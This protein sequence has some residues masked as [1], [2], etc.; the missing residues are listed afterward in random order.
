MLFR[1]K[2]QSMRMDVESY[3]K[4]F[5]FVDL[6]AEFCGGVVGTGNEPTAEWCDINV[7]PFVIY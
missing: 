5:I 1:S 7:A 3:I 2:I 4:N 6:T